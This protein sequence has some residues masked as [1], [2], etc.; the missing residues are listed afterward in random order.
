MGEVV[1]RKW[2]SLVGGLNYGLM[3]ERSRRE[4]ESRT[5]RG[6]RVVVSVS[7]TVTMK[8]GLPAVSKSR[9]VCG[10]VEERRMGDGTKE[11]RTVRSC[12]L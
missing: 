6:S 2:M 5:R 1:D 4:G 3:L 11:V 7:S 10:W 9:R 12:D 8:R